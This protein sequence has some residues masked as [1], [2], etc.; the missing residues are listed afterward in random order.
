MT[1]RE[2][3]FWSRVTVTSAEQCWIWQGPTNGH[4]YGAFRDLGFFTS[5]HRFAYETRNGAIPPGL[6]I[7]HLCRT[8]R[9]VNP[10][11]LEAV[12]QRENV[13]RGDG[14]AAVNALKTH[15]PQGHAYTP[16]N[17]YTPPGA[18]R[19]VCR[20]C[21]AAKSA[22]HERKRKPLIEAAAA[23]LGITPTAYMNLHGKSMRKALQIAGTQ[24]QERE[25]ASA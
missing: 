23:S 19:R 1:D 15:C 2:Q 5:A 10:A 9:C 20:S 8:P 21:M 4:G 14:P 24:P 3:R 7:D 11:H 17:I 13:L 22:R 18:A 12:T 16:E 25:S 6:V